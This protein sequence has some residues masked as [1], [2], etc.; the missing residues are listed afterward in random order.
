MANHSAN[1]LVLRINCAFGAFTIADIV[2]ELSGL[3]S[4]LIA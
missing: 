2:S 3:K 1:I 4:I